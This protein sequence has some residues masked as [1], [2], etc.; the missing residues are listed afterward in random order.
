MCQVDPAV[1][2][3]GGEE[4]EIE[5]E[6]RAHNSSTVMYAT[7]TPTMINGAAAAPAWDTMRAITT[8]ESGSRR[9]ETAMAP[10]STPTAGVSLRPG[11]CEASSPATI[12]MKI[13]GKVGPP[14]APPSDTPHAESL[15]DDDEYQRAQ[16]QRPCLLD[17]RVHGLLPREE[18]Q[19]SG[20]IRDLREAD[21]EQCNHDGCQRVAHEG[22]LRDDLAGSPTYLDD[23]NGHDGRND[24]EHDRPQ[25]VAELRYGVHGSESGATA[26]AF[27]LRPVRDPAPVKTS[28]PTP[29]ATRPGRSTRGSVGPP[30]PAASMM[31]TAPMMGEPK[32]VA[33]AAKLAAATSTSF[34]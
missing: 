19:A 31:M 5:V 22:S 34:A 25:E 11:K 10:I 7:T 16:R 6:R 18:H 24:A 12:P 30:S 32:I 13:A 8:A 3:G 23:R 20:L 17:D 27:E 1:S 9:T 26:Y 15:E 2:V 33:R 21:S 4:A 29:V 28:E 14:R